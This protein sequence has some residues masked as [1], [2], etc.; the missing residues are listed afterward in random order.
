[1]VED[2]LLHLEES[3][4]SIGFEIQN[5]EPFLMPSIVAIVMLVV[6]VVFLLLI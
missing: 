4:D 5:L 1:M 6:I 3:Y 2:V